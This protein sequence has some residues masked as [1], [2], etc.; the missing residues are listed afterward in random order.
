[1]EKK[2]EMGNQLERYVQGL[3]SLGK[4]FWIGFGLTVLTGIP[5]VIVKNEDAKLYLSGASSVGGIV[6]LS[7]MYTNRKKI[8]DCLNPYIT[9]EELKKKYKL[10][11]DNFL[12]PIK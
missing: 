10:T 11:G 12:Y 1:M 8:K 3:K 6:T 2:I 5:S 4:A 7:G 9:N